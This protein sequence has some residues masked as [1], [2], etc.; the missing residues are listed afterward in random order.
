MEAGDSEELSVAVL[1]DGGESREHLVQDAVVEGFVDGGGLEAGLVKKSLIGRERWLR[2]NVVLDARR[3]S[4]DDVCHAGLP[5][6]LRRDSA[7]R[8]SKTGAYVSSNVNNEAS[9]MRVSKRFCATSP[10][11]KGPMAVPSRGM[12][13]YRPSDL[14]RWSAF[15][16]SL[17]TPAPI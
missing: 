12:E 3:A 2:M 6:L 8:S 1:P 4:C 17:S 10:P 14:P 5:A 11:T 13:A 15:Q 9:M 7:L 16:Q